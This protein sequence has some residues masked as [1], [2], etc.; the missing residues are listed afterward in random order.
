MTALLGESLELFAPD[1]AQ[2][3]LG[4]PTAQPAGCT[5]LPVVLAGEAEGA[6][7]LSGD[8]APE[9]AVSQRTASPAR[10]RSRR[11]A[12]GQHAGQQR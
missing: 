9:D 11:G 3:E 12:R 8:L 4:E 7:W 6:A 10:G 1:A 2:L 5:R